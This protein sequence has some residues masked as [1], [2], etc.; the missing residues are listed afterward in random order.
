M[1]AL[2][3]TEMVLTWYAQHM[4]ICLLETWQRTIYY[5]MCIWFPVFENVIRF[6]QSIFSI[7]IVCLVIAIRAKYPWTLLSIC[8]CLMLSVLSGCL[9]WSD[10]IASQTT[11]DTIR[12]SSGGI[13]FH[14]IHPIIFM[15]FSEINH[16]ET[17]KKYG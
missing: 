5:Y 17:G 3:H 7:F 8:C 12:G 16:G 10:V 1:Y 9:F 2:L 4:S 15:L 6:S 11:A 14:L 13:T